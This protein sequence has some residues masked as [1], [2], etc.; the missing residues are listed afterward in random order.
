VVA[1]AIARPRGI[2]GP[3][4]PAAGPDAG[5]EARTLLWV[6]GVAAIVLLIACANVTNLMLARIL[7]RRR[8]IAMRLALGVSRRRLAGQ[9]V[10]EGLLLAALGCIAGLG[11]AQWGGAALQLLMIPGATAEGAGFDW[12]TLAGGLRLR[13]GG[14]RG[15]VDRARAARGA[16]RPGHDAPGGSP[17]RRLS[18][19]SYPLGAS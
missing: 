6:T 12:R 16:R 2:A 15:H 19:L 4:K 7:R 13:A 9:L 1:A 3:L 11:L 17:R 18:T 14:R 5:L 8:E 10:T